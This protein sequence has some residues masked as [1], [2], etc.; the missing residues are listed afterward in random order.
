MQE[1]VE[2]ASNTWAKRLVTG[3]KPSCPRVFLVVLSA[4]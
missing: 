4:S 3:G 1:I 2:L